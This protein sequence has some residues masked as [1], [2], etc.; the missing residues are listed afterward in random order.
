MLDED[1]TMGKT[2][3]LMRSTQTT[4]AKTT[5]RKL[6][7]RTKTGA[8]AEINGDAI[9]KEPQGQEDHENHQPDSIEQ[10]WKK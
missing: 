2:Q 9:A 4:Q 7:T 6:T 3:S 8:G 5:I 1:E 10:N